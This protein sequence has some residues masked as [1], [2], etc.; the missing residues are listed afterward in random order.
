MLVDGGQST[1]S[2]QCHLGAEG[3]SNDGG[4]HS[5]TGV[6]RVLFIGYLG[7]GQTSGMRRAA[8]ERLGYEI[9]AVEAGGLWQSSGY[10]RRQLEQLSASGARIENLNA[11]VLDAAARFQPQLVWAEKQEYLRAQ[12]IRKLRANGAIALHYNPDPYY[13]LSWKRTRLADECIAVYDA[14]VITKRYELDEYRRHASGT[15]I[16]SPLGYDRI[17]HAPPAE[18]VA[19]PREKVV[20]VGGWEPRRER[21]LDAAS[22]ATSDVAVW[23]YGWGIAQR[24]RLNLLRALRLGRLTPGRS[25]YFGAPHERLASAIRAGEG[26]NGEIYEDRYA[27]VVAASQIALGFLRELNPDQHTTRSFEIPAIGGFMLADRTEDHR[28]FFEEGKEAEYFSSDDEFRDKVRFYLANGTARAR[29]ARAGHERCM[30]SGYSYDDRIRT[31]LDEL[32]L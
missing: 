31:V 10:A 8:L 27:G 20:F 13:S 12:T 18:R 6:M 19:N 15:V 21:L 2:G 22:E 16:Y 11:R 23:G 1:R 26:S 5:A 28:E 32:K 29:I 3:R 25:V 7:R 17:G 9:E 4:A 30:T 24:S 14:L